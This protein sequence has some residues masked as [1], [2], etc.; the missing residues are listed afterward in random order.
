MHQLQFQFAPD[1]VRIQSFDAARMLCN[2]M[3]SS[4]QTQDCPGGYWLCFALELQGREWLKI[5]YLAGDEICALSHQNSIGGRGC[6]HASG[7]TYR[8]IV[9]WEEPAALS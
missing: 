3:R 7:Y 5:K 6:L 4:I 8:G 9:H 2:S 1:K